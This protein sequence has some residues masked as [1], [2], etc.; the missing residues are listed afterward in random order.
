MTREHMQAADHTFAASVAET[1]DSLELQAEDRAA[2]RLAEKYAR[3]LDEA[4]AAEV[5]ADKVLRR[6]D[7]DDPDPE[8]AELV[9]ALRGKLSARTALESLGPKLL[10]VLDALGGSPKARASAGKTAGKGG[11]GGKLAEL[12]AARA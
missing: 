7:D 8:L 3:A 11:K 12:R 4:R 1:L 2:G 10:S 6:L 9:S 5:Q